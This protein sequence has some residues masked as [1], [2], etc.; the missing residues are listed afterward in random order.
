MSR[1]HLVRVGVMGEIGRFQPVDAVRYPRSSRVIVRTRRGLEIGEI[2]V[3]DADGNSAEPEGTILRR[4]T[5][6]DNLL[7]SR[8][9]KN[10]S[11]AFAACSA[12]LAELASPPVLLD[13]EHL[14]DG[15]S[16]YFY[17]LGEIR[18]EVEAITN[19]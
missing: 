19:E 17:F 15:R 12:R 6:E 4:M 16:L 3:P 14:F 8:L 11:E 2:L 5:T 7:E 9:L 1:N 10:R 18:P 13:V